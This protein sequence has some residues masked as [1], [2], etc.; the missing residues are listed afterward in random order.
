M[1]L[2]LRIPSRPYKKAIGPDMLRRFRNAWQQI[3]FLGYEVKRINGKGKWWRWLGC[4]FTATFWVIAS[5]RIERAL[6]LAFGPAWSLMRVILAPLIFLLRPWIGAGEISYIADLGR[7]LRV[8]H[9]GLGVV[10]TQHTHAGQHLVL[11]GGNCIGGWP[12]IV[13]GDNVMMGVNSVILGPVRIGDNAQIGAGAVVVKDVPDNETVVGV[14]A[15][16]LKRTIKKTD[17]NLADLTARD[18]DATVT[19]PLLSS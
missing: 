18:E 15:H 7:G 9:P 4:W 2:S 6:Y 14:P 16:P 1:L 10:V 17:E 11:T 19:D 12:E 13:L 3:E 5:Y 8:L